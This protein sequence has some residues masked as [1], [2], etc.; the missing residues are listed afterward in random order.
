MINSP[1]TP[2]NMEPSLNLSK[3]LREYQYR[4][5]LSSTLS[6][7]YPLEE[8]LDTTQISPKLIQGIEE[9]NIHKIGPLTTEIGSPAHV[10]PHSGSIDFIIPAGSKILA[11]TKG[12]VVQVI[13]CHPEHLFAKHLFK[14][15]GPKGLYRLTGRQAHKLNQII[16][17]HVNDGA[18]EFT[19]YA[20]LSLHGSQ[21]QVGQSVETGIEIGRTGWSGW[22]DR[23]HLHFQVFRTENL[24]QWPNEHFETLTPQWLNQS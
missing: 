20:H 9:E 11:A 12:E 7:Q 13:D 18:A 5:P 10:G 3:E 17:R 19:R 21:V 2:I 8:T 4:E 16:I 22:M 23:P 15:L 14:G 6:Y 24:T 1:K